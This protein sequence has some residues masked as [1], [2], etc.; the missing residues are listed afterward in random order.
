MNPVP[1]T[2]DGS[3]RA[4]AIPFG[5]ARFWSWQ[6]AYPKV[7]APLLG[8]YALLAEWNALM[9][10]ATEYSVA[11]LKLAWWQEEVRRLA[12]G[13]PVHPI[14][15]YLFSL[16]GAAQVDF[17]CLNESIDAA[18]AEVSGA[19]LE[20]S[21]ELAPHAQALRAQPMA[22]ASR[23]AGGTQDNNALAECTQLLALADYLSRS[24][25]GYRREASFGRVPF[26]VEELIANGIENADLTADPPPARLEIYLQHLRERALHTFD[27]VSRALPQPLRAAQRHLLVLA[28]LGR[29]GLVQHIAA[30]QPRGLQDM[31]LAWKTARRASS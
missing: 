14:G 31:L 29:R 30:R 13:T 19:P 16:P 17:A 24:I 7:R 28:A 22:M 12:A 18:L 26:A 15:I 27:E 3:Y 21:S 25:S 2:L 11:C 4:Q 23:L 1:R 5:S 20:R 10:P 8:I 6:F 9:D